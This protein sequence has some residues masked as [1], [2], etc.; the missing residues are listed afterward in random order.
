M[1]GKEQVEPQYTFQECSHRI[2]NIALHNMQL[3]T[4]GIRFSGYPTLVIV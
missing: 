1:Y 4:Q 3:V 2:R